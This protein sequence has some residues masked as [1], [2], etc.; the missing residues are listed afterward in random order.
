M[1]LLGIIGGILSLVIASAIAW[2]AVAL[3]RPVILPLPR[4]SE[5]EQTHTYVLSIAGLML[6][7]WQIVAPAAFVVLLALVLVALAVYAFTAREEV[8]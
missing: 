7:G 1:S 6:E 8:E 5:A 3:F 4:G 2:P